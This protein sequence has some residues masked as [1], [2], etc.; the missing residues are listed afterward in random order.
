MQQYL[1]L[2][3]NI[4]DT[5]VEKE[6]SRNNLPNTIGISNGIIKMDLQ[7][8]FPLLTTKQI[9]WKSIIHELL[10]FLRGDTNI[11]YLVDNN[12]HIWDE[13]AYRW[14][15]KKVES[16][17]KLPRKD[18]SKP[19]L[20]TQEKFIDTI[21]NINTSEFSRGIYFINNEVHYDFKNPVDPEVKEQLEYLFDNYDG[22]GD[23]GSLCQEGY[24]LG[25]LGKVYGH[26]WRNQNGVDQIKELLEG[27]QKTPFSRYHIINAWNR[28]DFNDMALPPCHL[29]YQFIVRP[30][31]SYEREDYY[32]KIHNF[33]EEQRGEMNPNDSDEHV[34]ILMDESNIPRFYLDLNMYQRS[35]DV[36]LGVPFNLAS[37]SILLEIFAK[38]CNMIPGIATWIGGDTHIYLP[39]IENLKEQL[40]R[41]PY[42]LAQIKILKDIK[43]LEDIT[44]LTIDDFVLDNYKSHSKINFKL[45]SGLIK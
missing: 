3:Q 30:L 43:T 39:H 15:L 38:I 14:Y 20:D 34:H 1:D 37:M 27:L 42:K 2:V 8:G 21:K 40:K 45:F 29:L 9:A 19:L 6:S 22:F 33:S 18:Y 32:A 16:I 24:R 11:K 7:N 41:T 17:P 23:E 25:D 35:A 4:L 10:W 28:V 36:A 12:V 31:T 44:S 26:Q 13:D 5:G